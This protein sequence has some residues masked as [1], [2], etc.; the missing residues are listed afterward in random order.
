MSDLDELIAE[1]GRTHVIPPRE[2]PALLERLR[3][4]GVLARARELLQSKD[5][6]ERHRA[7]LCIERIGYVVRDQ[8]TAELL[9]GH[10][11]SSKDKYEV[12]TALDALKGCHP[13]RPLPSEPLVRLAGNREWLVWQSAVR[14]LH[15]AVADEVEPALLERLDADREGLVY[16]AIELRYM[17]SS[18]SIRVLEQLLGHES[19]DV[20]CVA[21]DSLGVRLGAGVLPYARRLGGGRQQAEKLWAEEWLARFGDADDVPFMIARVKS[22]LSGKRQI[23]CEPPEV[24]RVIPFL[25]RYPDLPQALAVLDALRRRAERL[26]ENERRWLEAH[27]PEVLSQ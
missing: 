20:R 5:R 18:E 2:D 7:I 16:V 15:L 27:T 22:L 3:D 8:E 21:L 14:C 9:L 12:S 10:A 1:A 23:Q 26:P 4:P 17:H 19:L 11:D 13:P 6:S 24:S 25:L